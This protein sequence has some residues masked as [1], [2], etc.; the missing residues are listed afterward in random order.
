M[1][2]LCIT[3]FQNSCTFYRT[4]DGLEM[5]I[6]GLEPPRKNHQNL[7]L[8]CLPVSSYPQDF[9]FSFTKKPFLNFQGD[10]I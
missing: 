8:T 6:E 9:G 5:R 1:K 10:R 7:N 2:F 4:L 3:I